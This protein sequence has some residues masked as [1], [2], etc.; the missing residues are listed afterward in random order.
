MTNY[1]I[2]RQQIK[3]FDTDGF[4]RLPNVINAEWINKGREACERAVSVKVIP[5]SEG[6]DYF[7]KL[8][9][10]END[11]VFR[12]LATLSSIPNIAARLVRSQKINLLYDQ[13][14]NLAPR[15]G[16]RTVWHHDLP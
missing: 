15:S 8:R 13:M 6:P 2:S 14:F 12:H 7:M 10:W 16:D 5:G 4:V 3:K 9:V 1:S 11:D